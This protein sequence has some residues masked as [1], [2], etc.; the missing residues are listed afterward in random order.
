[1]L[2]QLFRSTYATIAHTYTKRSKEEN[3]SALVLVMF[4]VLLLTILGVSVLSAALGGGQRTETR[5]NDVQSLHLAEKTLDEAVAYVTSNLNKK[6]KESKDLS[7]TDLEREINNYLATLQS[8]LMASTNLTNAS[9][10]ITNVRYT[11]DGVI[12]N[13]NPVKYTLTLMAEAEVNGVVRKLT[14]KVIIDTLPDFL[15]YTLGS[16]GNLTINGAPSIIGNIYA[17]GKLTISDTAQYIYKIDHTHVSS[18]FY[19]NGEAHVQSLDQLI[20][21]TSYPV[22]GKYEL[23]ASEITDATLIVGKIEQRN[24]KIKSQRKFVQVDVEKT[25]VDKIM[26]AL[27][28]GATQTSIRSEINN[29]LGLASGELASYLKTFNGIFDSISS[30]DL[31]KPVL[32]DD[33]T[34]EQEEEFEAAMAEYSKKVGIIQHPKKSVIYNGNLTLDGSQDFPGILYSV[35]DKNIST[36]RRWFII[37]GDLKIDNFGNSPV[38]VRANMLVTGKVEIRGDVEIDST[39][40]VLKEPTIIEGVA[41]YTTLVEDAS[42]KGLDDKELVLMS[43]GPILINRLAA[44]AN[45]TS[46]LDAFFYTDFNADLYGVGS[47]LSL[48]GGFF[49]KGDLTINAVRGSVSENGND[50]KFINDVNIIRFKAEYNNKIL[51]DQKAGLPRVQTVN[52]S[53]EDL[54]LE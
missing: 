8:G 47:M 41:E 27:G 43:K 51:D 32:V 30:S 1:M 53:V 28:E 36:P 14:K 26:E 11:S 20:Y 33:P 18:P 29:R 24:V 2:R 23:K 49:A 46:P 6:V 42:I 52:I 37:D 44:F 45:R 38:R 31:L 16:E 21:Q 7:Q 15:R 50:L 34:E 25:F 9:G 4:I 40:Y 35:T 22:D 13:G 17:G 10:K 19:L 12:G 3:G 54:Q 39:M 5:K 48:S